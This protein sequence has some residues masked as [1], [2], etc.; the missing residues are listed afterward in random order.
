LAD[1]SRFAISNRRGLGCRAYVKDCSSFFPTTG[2]RDE[3][4][5]A[6]HGY[7][8]VVVPVDKPRYGSHFTH[9][10]RSLLGSKY[11]LKKKEQW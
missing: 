3:H 6:L 8:H 9:M 4:E 5:K 11:D 2:E 7:H 10:G 1:G